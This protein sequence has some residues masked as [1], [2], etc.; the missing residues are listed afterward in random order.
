[1]RSALGVLILGLAGPGTARAACDAPASV[2]ARVDCLVRQVAALQVDLGESQA[3]VVAQQEE[4]ADLRWALGVQERRLGVVEGR[5]STHGV[6]LEVAR[7]D[8]R[9]LESDMD[10]IGVAVRGVRRDQ[11][12]A[13]T[14]ADADAARVVDLER[15]VERVEQAALQATERAT[16][17]KD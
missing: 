12:V 2:E 6:E 7:H 11:Q 8:L 17:R 3:Q 9:G 13:S 10:H 1:M 16:A 5:V 4:L 14:D 15:R